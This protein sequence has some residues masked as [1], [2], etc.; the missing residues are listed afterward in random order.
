MSVSA[1]ANP[2]LHHTRRNLL[3][4][5]RECAGRPGRRGVRRRMQRRDHPPM[6]ARPRGRVSVARPRAPSAASFFCTAHRARLERT[7]RRRP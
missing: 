1:L 7:R 5:A 2:Q 3:D 4:P 6:W